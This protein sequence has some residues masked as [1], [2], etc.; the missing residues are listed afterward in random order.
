MRI[1]ILTFLLVAPFLYFR[2]SKNTSSEPQIDAI[3]TKMGAPERVAPDR[4]LTLKPSETPAAPA[5]SEAGTEVVADASASSDD[6]ADLEHIEEVSL[7]DLEEGW[8]TELKS[9]LSR[10][11]PVDGEN[12]FNSWKSEQ[13]SYQA[14][15]DA[16]MSEK[17]QKT[18]EEGLE[19][20]QMI[21]QLDE[22]H[23]AKLKDILG[24]HYEA[25]RDHYD[26]YMESAQ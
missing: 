24:A 17:Q 16:L 9:M 1:F 14:E 5:D 22:K 23:Q 25:V 11:E 8:N 19:I 15:M 18:G 7:P 12:M 13:E 26:Q 20:D 2:E 4:I 6:E 21:A 3:K 10:L